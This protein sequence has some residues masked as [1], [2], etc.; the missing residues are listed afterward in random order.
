LPLAQR[1]SRLRYW[2]LRHLRSSAIRQSS[3]MADN[4]KADSR[5]HDTIVL[6]AGM[7]G[8]GV[9][10]RLLEH[11]SYQEK[12]LLVL[13]ARDRVGGRIESVLVNGNRLDTGANWI[14]GSGTEDEPNPLVHILPDK[15]LTE[16]SRSVSF[17]PS[18]PA[19]VLESHEVNGLANEHDWVSVD[20]NQTASMQESKGDLVIPSHIAGDLFGAMWTLIGSLH[21]MATNVSSEKAYQTSMLDAITR[22]EAFKSAFDDAPKEYH[23]T[24]RALPQVVEAME[25]GPLYKQSAEHSADHPGMGLLEFAIDDFDGEQA[26]LCDGYTAVVEEVGKEVIKNGYVKLGVKVQ[27]I[28]WDTEQIVISTSDGQYTADRVVCTLPLGVLQS[29]LRPESPSSD[30]VPLFVPELP[31]EQMEAITSLGFGTLDKIFMVYNHPWWIEDPYKSILTKGLVDLPMLEGEENSV[32]KDESTEFHS[33]L[34]FTDELPGLAIGPDGAKLGVRA[35]SVVNLHA[36]TSFPVLSAFVSCAN[37]VHVES[38]SDEAAKMIVHRSLTSGMGREPPMPDA[39]HVTRW[40]QD[41]YSRGSY[42]H[43]ITGLSKTSHRETFQSPVVNKHGAELRFA[44]EHTSRNHFATVHGALL[45]G[46]R[47]ADAI[48]ESETTAA[49]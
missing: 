39:V 10:A 23:Q 9:A 17:R 16:L 24:L 8:L 32:G 36:L 43:L 27:S 31:S 2:P 14:H 11:P 42:S 1:L 34:G 47:E 46:W 7:A 30:L 38:L 3:G 44:G 45:S 15:K 6:G 37:A 18:A 33:M 19:N 28:K 29:H 20:A 26:F 5:H 22:D 4:T 48:I 25:A 13:E 12:S 49:R 41:E 35:I 21:K 40:A